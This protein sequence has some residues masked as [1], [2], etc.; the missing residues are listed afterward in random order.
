VR[1]QVDPLAL[2]RYES[3]H[4]LDRLEAAALETRLAGAPGCVN[5]PVRWITTIYLDGPGTPLCR[6]LVQGSGARSRIRIRSYGVPGDPLFLER[7]HHRRG[8]A[9]KTRVPIAPAALPA[10]IA[11]ADPRARL[12]G[13]GRLVQAPLPVCTVRYERRIY[14][15]AAGTFRFT[16]DRALGAAAVAPDWLERLAAG[17]LPAVEPAP[18]APVVVECKHLGSPPRW[19][20]EALAP[21]LA[22]DF[23]KLAWAFLR[24]RPGE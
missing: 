14:R 24:L 12:V 1:L 15:D 2:R 9:L 23:S 18:D 11:G 5:E 21:H 6:R 4:L 17:E 20:E 22:P 7:K 3:K 8:Q 13:I 10:V 16:I 19:I